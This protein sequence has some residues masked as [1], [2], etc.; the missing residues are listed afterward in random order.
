M[1][2]LLL[3]SIVLTVFSA[4]IVLFQLSCKKTAEAQTGTSYSLPPATTTNL[5]GIIVGNGL[6]VTSN[7]TL[8]VNSTT[9]GIYQL[10]KIVFAKLL[11]GGGATEIWTMNYD[12]T[13]QTKANITMPA[14]QHIT[15]EYPKLSPDGTKIVFI[16]GTTGSNGNDDDIYISNIDGSGVTKIYDMPVGTGHTL[17]GG[18]Y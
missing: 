11:T 7:G 12:G 5:G 1:K 15:D 9:G 2:K 13:N 18:A 3:S 4:S 14:G 6:S 10:N 8:S 17:L 16:G